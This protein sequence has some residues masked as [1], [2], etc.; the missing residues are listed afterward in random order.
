LKSSDL[1]R[2]LVHNW[3][4]KILSLA[5]AVLLVVFNNVSRLEER[6]FSVPLELKLPAEY[7]PAAEYP[8][9]VRIVLRGESEEIFR[10][11]EQ[12]IRAYVDL[13]EHDSSGEYQE[14]VEIERRTSSLNVQPLEIEV[15][16]QEITV[17]LD[18]MLEKGVPVVPSLQGSPPPGYELSQYE[19]S[20]SSVEVQGPEDVVREI[21]RL[22]TEDVDLGGRRQSFTLRVRLQKPDPFI[23]FPGGDV[24]EFRGTI[25]ERVLLQTFE[26][27]GM[28]VVGLPP[29][30]RLA[31]ELPDGELRVQGKQVQLAELDSSD[32]RLILD[33]SAVSSTGSHTLSV[34]P[35]VP[36]GLLVLRYEPQELSVRVEEVQPEGQQ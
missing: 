11:E 16:P 3:P 19:L 24:V 21:E 18:R 25:K 22:N 32:L 36:T 15:E 7:V 13:S 12:D 2:R 5:A 6:F 8:Q 26:G 14:P 20:P 10:I 29:D 4:A 17:R 28:V 30:L 35:Q 9:Q 31:D 33:A 23:S 27:V 34:R 1:L